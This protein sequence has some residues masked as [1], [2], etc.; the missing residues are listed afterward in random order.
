MDLVHPGTSSPPQPI[1]LPNVAK[2]IK[3][4]TFDSEAAVI[5]ATRLAFENSNE[6]GVFAALTN[7]YCL[8]GA[9]KL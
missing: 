5:M 1:V 4:A 3:R 8:T 6:V 2:D 9:I 7:A